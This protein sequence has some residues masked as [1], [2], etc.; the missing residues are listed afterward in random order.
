M[1]ITEYQILGTTP[2]KG[3]ELPPLDVNLVNNAASQ[4]WRVINSYFIDGILV[5]VFMER[6]IENPYNP[7]LPKVSLR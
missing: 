5:T 4:G 6:I 1:L 7:E 3:Y 2:I